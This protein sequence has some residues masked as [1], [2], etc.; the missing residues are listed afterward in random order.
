MDQNWI[1]REKRYTMLGFRITININLKIVKFLDVTLNLKKGT[2]EPY[3][4][5]NEWFEEV[6]IHAWHPKDMNVSPTITWEILKLTP[7]YSKTS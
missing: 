4:K 3:K 2:F 1:A 7:A 6:C 5:E